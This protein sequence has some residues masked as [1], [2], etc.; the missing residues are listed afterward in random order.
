[1]G[2]YGNPIAADLPGPCPVSSVLNQ[3]IYYLAITLPFNIQYNYT[4][5]A[6]HL[7]CYIFYMPVGIAAETLS[8]VYC[9]LLAV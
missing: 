8:F 2:S 5:K 7:I 6:Y 9:Q 4:Y 3:N 1:M